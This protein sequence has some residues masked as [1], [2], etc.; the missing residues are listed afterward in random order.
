MVRIC[1]IKK[2]LFSNFKMFVSIFFF[3]KLKKAKLVTHQLKI[4]WYKSLGNSA[5]DN[6]PVCNKEDHKKIVFFWFSLLFPGKNEQSPEGVLLE[7][8]SS[9]FSLRPATL[10]KKRFQHGCFPVNFAKFQRTPFFTKHFRWLPSLKKIGLY[11]N[12]LL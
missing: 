7:R 1:H 8:C 3:E 12:T 2:Y 6:G 9:K 10:L 5:I 4:Y 11:H